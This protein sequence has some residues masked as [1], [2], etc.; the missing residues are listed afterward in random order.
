[1]SDERRKRKQARE[2]KPKQK[3]SL[4]RKISI[5]V[6]ILAA[7][8][9]V[10]YLG[11]RKRTSRLDAFARCTAQSGAKMYGAYW[12]PH[13]LEQKE[14]FGSAFQY[15]NYVECGIKGNAKGQ[16]QACI[17]AGIKHYPTW[18]FANASRVEGK[19]DLTSLSQKTG[20]SLP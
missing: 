8:A 17:D 18:V 13:C 3:T 12:C 11:I 19:Q 2:P 14:T 10:Y 9:L 16:T 7:F 1:M 4:G 15:V 5:G 20:C 6:A